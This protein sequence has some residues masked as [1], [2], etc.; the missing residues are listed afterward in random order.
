MPLHVRRVFLDARPSVA[1]IKLMKFDET[2]VALS[3]EPKKGQWKRVLWTLFGI[4]VVWVLLTIWAM[5][6]PWGEIHPGVRIEPLRVYTEKDVTPGCFWD[7]QEKAVAA[8]I[9]P[10]D[11]DK[12]KEDFAEI[13][14][15]GRRFWKESDYPELAKHIADNQPTLDLLAEAGRLV[16]GFSLTTYDFSG[17]FSLGTLNDLMKLA[18]AQAFL[19]KPEKV[20]ELIQQRLEE[21]LRFGMHMDEGATLLM[22]LIAQARQKMAL[23]AMRNAAEQGVGSEVLEA[24]SQLLKKAEPRVQSFPERLRLDL[25]KSE[26]EFDKH[27]M[28]AAV[29]FDGRMERLYSIRNVI[30]STKP[31]QIHNL[32][33]IYS[34]LIYE[35]ERNPENPDFQAP[36]DRFLKVNHEWT[37]Y[38][39]AD[40]ITRLSM[41]G[42]WNSYRG[43]YEERLQLIANF[44]AT[45]AMFALHDYHLKTGKWPAALSDAIAEVPMDPFGGKPL[46]YRLCP[47]GSC[48]VYSLGRNRTD[49]GGDPADALKENLKDDVYPSNELELREKDWQAEVAKKAG[50]SS[51]TKPKGAPAVKTK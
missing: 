6:R 5:Q 7:L 25:W 36:F 29:F 2:E 44:R 34:E 30:G 46:M 40:P 22:G 32:K 48:V 50:I 4:L 16:E 14:K 10:A 33:T 8:Y 43:I 18:L 15:R 49:E 21:S 20:P 13:S 51:K 24:W 45:R 1:T 3:I 42:S 39:K 47:D 28:G 31:K 35:M 12:I 27:E 26:A 17:G 9:K 41:I 19:T 23:K 37:V 38:L 11:P